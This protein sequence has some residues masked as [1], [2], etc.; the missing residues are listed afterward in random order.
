M[1]SVSDLFEFLLRKRGPKLEGLRADSAFVVQGGL[2]GQLGD[3]QNVVLDRFIMLVTNLHQTL[4]CI[5][6]NVGVC[7]LKRLKNLL[8]DKVAFFFDLEVLFHVRDTMYEGLYRK[9]AE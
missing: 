5:L 7:L 3:I 6:P 8:H 1:M 4:H 9:L 2:R